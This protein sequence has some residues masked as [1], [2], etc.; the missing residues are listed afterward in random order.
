MPP[1]I[2]RAIQKGQK[3]Y[4][5]FTLLFLV[6]RTP[7]RYGWGNLTIKRRKFGVKE[8]HMSKSIN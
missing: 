3:R 4:K 2:G 6:L 7:D 8:G 1:K 5:I